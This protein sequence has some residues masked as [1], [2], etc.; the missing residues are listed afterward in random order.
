MTSVP[1]ENERV[2]SPQH[3]MAELLFEN[4]LSAVTFA[5]GAA[6]ILGS[7]DGKHLFATGMQIL[8]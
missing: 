1:Q 6:Q 7:L 3:E 8:W 4:E 5:A 2:P